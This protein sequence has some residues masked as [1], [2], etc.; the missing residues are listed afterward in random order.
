MTFAIVRYYDDINW[1]LHEKSMRLED[2]LG[3]HAVAAKQAELSSPHGGTGS[4]RSSDGASRPD[5]LQRRKKRKKAGK[6]AFIAAIAFAGPRKGYTFKEGAR[7]TGY[8]K[9]A[10]EDSGTSVV[11]GDDSSDI[12]Q[13]VPPPTTGNRR[14]GRTRAVLSLEE[15]PP[16][17]ELTP[18][19]LEGTPRQK[20]DTESS[21]WVHGVSGE[22]VR[23]DAMGGI[24]EEDDEEEEEEEESASESESVQEQAGAAGQEEEAPTDDVRVPEAAPASS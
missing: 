23:P 18:R 12:A 7:G 14:R 6:A 3:R 17:E 16:D 11:P 19:S 1:H 9:D 4:R 10:Q 24:I 13:P 15:Q 2:Y 5:G 22:E 21:T 8:Y 20:G